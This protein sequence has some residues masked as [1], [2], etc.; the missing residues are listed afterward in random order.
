MA[1]P[2]EL[3]ELKKD[4]GLSADDTSDD[5]QL[6]LVLDAAIAFVEGPLGRAGDFNFAGDEESELR[7]PNRDIVLGTLR[8][9]RRQHTRR[10]SPDG[11]ADLG[12][13][14]QGRVPSTDPDIERFLGIG[15][16]RETYVA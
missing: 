7:E 13:L 1:W 5:E 8:L 12:E 3:T 2:P 11:L 6:Q 10:N 14:G 16:Y 9:A 15:R 4:M